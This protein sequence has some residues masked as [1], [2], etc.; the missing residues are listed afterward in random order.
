M[1][2][3]ETSPGRPSPLEEYRALHEKLGSMPL[4]QKQELLSGISDSQRA[5]L[6]EG[7]A[8][9]GR[10]QTQEAFRTIIDLPGGFDEVTGQA[11]E[12]QPHSEQVDSGGTLVN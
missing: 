4:P 11:S 3:E 1:S 8:A 2:Y 7:Q 6:M 9:H 12:P 5:V 10:A